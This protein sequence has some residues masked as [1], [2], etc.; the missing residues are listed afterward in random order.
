MVGIRV[1]WSN[2]SVN[3]RNNVSLISYSCA[4]IM[5]VWVYDIMLP[6]NRNVPGTVHRY[7]CNAVTY[8][9]VSRATI[10]AASKRQVRL[11]RKGRVMDNEIRSSSILNFFIE[12]H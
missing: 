10:G 5:H 7:V 1:E 11:V 2:E 4:N 3:N 12:V 6:S 8:S 9:F